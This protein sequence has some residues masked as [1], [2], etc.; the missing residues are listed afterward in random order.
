M[1]V[2]IL[3]FFNNGNF[4][5]ELQAVAMGTY[6][7]NLGHDPL[8]CKCRSTNLIGRILRLLSRVCKKQIALILN[9]EYRMMD[10]A[11]R[12]NASNQCV[13]SSDTKAKVRE[14]SKWL[15]NS[16]TLNKNNLKHGFDAYICGSDQIW[17]PLIMPLKKEYYLTFVPGNKK[18]AYAPSF[19]VASLPNYHKR[20]IRKYI[21]DFQYLSVRE[22]QGISIV[23]DLCGNKPQFVCD[24]TMLLTPDE[25]NGLLNA[26]SCGMEN[27]PD[28]YVLAYF[29][30]NLDEKMTSAINET[31]KGQTILLLPKRENC[32]YPNGISDDIGIFGFLEAIK[33]AKYVITDSFHG[34][35]FS[36]M[37]RKQF[38]VI[39]RNNAEEIK[40]VSRIESLLD[41][42][43]I[44]R[45]FWH[46][47][48]MPEN[49]I[50][51]DIDYDQVFSNL[52][53]YRMQ[54]REYLQNAL[55]EI[56]QNEGGDYN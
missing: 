34:T 32:P 26:N 12:A 30:S 14:D 49:I 2:A 29:L 47:K 42:L 25:W 33:N 27:L 31:C 23:E 37:F 44:K 21:A 7:Q 5:S 9:P 35:V 55:K 56:E 13:I 3:T 4:G 52:E 43:G 17:S 53:K 6:L 19:G 20:A 11:L 50:H 38:V 36:I 8:F 48:T 16:A 22:K 24:P 41:I 15:I 46:G 40:Q 51:E 18:I 1:R 45:R 28:Q 54:S 10:I 39:P